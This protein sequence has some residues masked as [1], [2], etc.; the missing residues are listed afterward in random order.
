MG[1]VPPGSEPANHF[2]CAKRPRSQEREGKKKTWQIYSARASSMELPFI[3]GW[4][5]TVIT[6]GYNNRFQYKLCG[7][8]GWQA[9]SMV[10]LLIYNVRWM[11]KK[12]SNKKRT[13]CHLL[14]LVCKTGSYVEILKKK[15]QQGMML[16]RKHN[17]NIIPQ[18]HLPV[19]H[20][21]EKPLKML[22]YP[23]S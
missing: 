18:M 17:V 14:W 13:I 5:A 21:V 11:L 22:R 8:R 16:K 3:H 1:A 20:F 10:S 7:N 6:Q 12:I 19:P 2:K 4:K 15:F 23:I 9:S